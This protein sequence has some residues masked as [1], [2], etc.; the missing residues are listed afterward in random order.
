MP[1]DGLQDDRSFFD[2]TIEKKILSSVSARQLFD[3]SECRQIEKKIDE[4][5]SQGRQG[6][7]KKQTVDRAPLRTKYFFG[8]GYTYGGQLKTRGPGNERLYPKGEVDPIPDWIHKLVIKP[9]EESGMVR[10]DWVNS[11]VVNDYL[12]GGCIVSHIDPPQLFDRP[13]IT[14]SFLS[15]SSLSFGCKFSFK[16][17]SVSSPL[18]QVPVSRGCVLSMEG[19]SADEVTHCIRP[20]DITERRAVVILRHVPHSAPRMTYRDLEELR[21]LEEQKNKH[22]QKERKPER[23]RSRSPQRRSRRSM[24]E[25]KRRSRKRRYSRSPKRRTEPDKKPRSYS[26]SRTSSNSRSCSPK[27]SFTNRQVLLPK[28]QPAVPGFVQNQ[29]VKMK[30]QEELSHDEKITKTVSKITENLEMDREEAAF[31]RRLEKLKVKISNE[32]ESA[33]LRESSDKEDLKKSQTNSLDESENETPDIVGDKSRKESGENVGLKHEVNELKKELRELKEVIKGL[34]TEPTKCEKKEALNSDTSDKSGDEEDTKTI[35]AVDIISREIRTTILS[36]TRT[37]T[38]ATYLII[39][40]ERKKKL[41]KSKLIE[42]KKEKK[43]IAEKVNKTSY[44]TTFRQKV[45]KQKF[46]TN[47]DTSTGSDSDDVDDIDGKYLMEAIKQRLEKKIKDD[48]KKFGQGS[49]NKR[50]HKDKDHKSLHRKRTAD[51]HDREGRMSRSVRKEAMDTEQ[52]NWTEGEEKKK[53]ERRGE[54]KQSLAEAVRK[55]IVL[56]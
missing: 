9:I 30:N 23:Q 16:P 22:W 52:G 14:A 20:E 46:R 41:L 26:S 6:L 35:N 53:E 34:K 21:R 1:Q 17:I 13:I 38:K 27:I 8:E 24:S 15:N 54:Q 4:I 56:K 33:K 11:A 3:R 49:K 44:G 42:L 43:K 51:R 39:K 5:V 18:A 19:F 12:P 31:Q 29:K 7:Y 45:K 37:T 25:E 48:Y 50:R 55:K 47:Q 36:K 32:M 28:L 10:K 40:A 2:Q